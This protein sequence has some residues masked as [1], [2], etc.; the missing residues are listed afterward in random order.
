MGTSMQKFGQWSTDRRCPN[1]LVD[2]TFC[3]TTN[4]NRFLCDPKVCKRFQ[5][6][7]QS[8]IFGGIRT[9]FAVSQKDSEPAGYF[10]SIT[11]DQPA[12]AE[13]TRLVRRIISRCTKHTVKMESVHRPLNEKQRHKLCRC[14]R[15][16]EGGQRSPQVTRGGKGLDL[17]RPH[18][19]QIILKTCDRWVKVMLSIS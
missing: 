4:F 2:H 14:L 17:M 16:G 12:V 7:D 19:G 5:P 13:Q 15:R 6:V 11:L 3:V 18:R 8:Q 1:H 10:R 9:C